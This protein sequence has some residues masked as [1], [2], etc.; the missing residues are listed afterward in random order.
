MPYLPG[1]MSVDEWK[2]TLGAVP[3]S[4]NARIDRV[5]RVW[6]SPDAE[7]DHIDVAYLGGV[8]GGEW[9]QGL[10]AQMISR[11]LAIPGLR[12]V[13]SA[14]QKARLSPAGLQCRAVILDRDMAA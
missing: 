9:P 5:L 6:P 11:R 12:T 7:L 13:P 10:L 4:G 2:A 1:P 8:R 3:V 14:L